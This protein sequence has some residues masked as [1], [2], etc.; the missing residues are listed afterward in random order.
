M[1]GFTPISLFP[2]LCREGGYDFGGVAARILE[3]ALERDAARP[4]RSL[5]REDLP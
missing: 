3:L 1:P 4:H 5:R 2:T